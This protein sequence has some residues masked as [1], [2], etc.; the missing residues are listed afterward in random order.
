MSSEHKSFKFQM[1]GAPDDQGHFT[2]YAAVFGNVD[3]GNDVIDPGACTKTLR[4]NPSVPLFWQHDYAGV[5][6]GVGTLT[7]DGVK[8][9]RIDGRL[10]I[11]TSDKAR[12]VFGAMKAKAV[13]GLSIGYNTIKKAFDGPVRRLQEIAIN[14]VSLCNTPMNPLATVDAG[15][16]KANDEELECVLALQ[17]V[18]M[19]MREWSRART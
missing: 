9:V 19:S 3:L 4:E 15:S 6:I 2:G 17:D 1:D 10:F 11:D 8:G 7:P 16:V 13:K 14:E 12:E 5:P 18:L